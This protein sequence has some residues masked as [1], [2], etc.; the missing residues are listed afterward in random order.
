[1]RRTGITL[2]ALAA[3][4]F[5]ALTVTTEYRR[6]SLTS[7]VLAEPRRLRLLWDELAAL[8]AVVL[9]AAVVLTALSWLI[10]LMGVT[11][12][13]HPLLLS[14]AEV[15]GFGLRGAVALV[16]YTWIGFAVGLLVRS[17]VSAL[18]VRGAAVVVESIV[19]PVAAQP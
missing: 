19:R 5:G 12:Q 4:I 13:G 6:G 14:P 17:P 2:P 9:G 18:V 7:A 8:G 3:L 1:M 10:L 11:V 16:L 15:A